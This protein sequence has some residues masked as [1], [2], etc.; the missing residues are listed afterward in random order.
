MMR[1][2]N[3]LFH[4]VRTG[5]GVAGAARLAGGIDNVSGI[6]VRHFGFLPGCAEA[7]H[8]HDSPTQEAAG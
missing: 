7:I 8:A 3:K 6:R 4:H 1:N 5:I 2:A